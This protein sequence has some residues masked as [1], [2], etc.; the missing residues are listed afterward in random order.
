MDWQPTVTLATAMGSVLLSWLL[1][2]LLFSG[3][4]I[5]VQRCMR[6]RPDNGWRWLEAFWLGWALTLG[7]LQLWHFAFPVDERALLLLAAVAAVMLAAE[8]RQLAANLRALRRDKVFLLAYG[9]VALWLANRSLGMPIAFDTGLRDMQ[10]VMWIDSYPIVPGLGNLYSS[11]AYNHSTYLYDA[12]LDAFYWSEGSVFIATGLLIMAYLAYAIKAARRTLSLQHASS[13]RWSQLFALVTIPYILS[14]SSSSGGIVH[15]LTDT[16]VDLLAFVTLIYALDLLQY[17]Q[18]CRRQGYYL[19]RLFFLIVA[20]MT[21]KQTFLLFGTV[22][23]AC[24]CL[25]WMLRG[26][27]RHVR[28]LAQPLALAVLCLAF[29]LPWMA[30]GVMT[31]G[32][33][34]YP[35]SFGRVELDWTLAADAVRHRQHVLSRNTRSPTNVKS[36]PDTL[37][38]LQP[39]LDRLLGNTFQQALPL[40]IAAASLLLVAI[41]RAAL[42][43]AERGRH[44]GLWVL[45]PI[46]LYLVLWF[47]SFPNIKYA[48]FAFWS[49]AALACLL[50]LHTWSTVAWRWP[51]LLLRCLLLACCAFIVYSILRQGSFPLAAGPAD[52]FRPHWEVGYDE[53]RTATGLVVHVPHAGNNQC[54]RVPLP[55][56]AY[57]NP[58]LEARQP[59]DLRH[60]FRM[61]TPPD[62]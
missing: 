57:F 32:Y 14:Y 34:A 60:G 45:T 22:L 59:G 42:P 35:Q 52:G 19:A 6:R 3:L 41:G 4:G 28:S 51:V 25:A 7:L 50:T 43:G 55:C 44:L 5:A 40:G 58:Q 33:V 29:L 56:T 53:V 61:A 18:P 27:H 48:R 24:I 38:W 31:S 47:L 11:L 54:W 37:N 20:G 1:Y 16:V 30:R 39:W 17:W 26:G 9:L 2:F 12:L 8:F 10:A 13:L 23:G 62:S 49:L 21:V 36:L 15:F 46:L